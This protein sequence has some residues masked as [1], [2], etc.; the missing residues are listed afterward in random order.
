MTGKEAADLWSRYQQIVE[1]G[2]DFQEWDQE[3]KRS[4]K[5]DVILHK[6]E[7]GKLSILREIIEAFEQDDVDV[8]E[9]SETG[10][11]LV[12]IPPRLSA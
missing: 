10:H 4:E 6:A 3:M 8:W 7:G 5:Q 2:A 9:D 11:T 12:V 1:R